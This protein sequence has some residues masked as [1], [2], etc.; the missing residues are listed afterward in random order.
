M[1]TDLATG[2]LGETGCLTPHLSQLAAGDPS[3]N[4]AVS[5]NFLPW[6]LRPSQEVEVEGGVWEVTT[7]H[8]PQWRLSPERGEAAR[9]PGSWFQWRKCLLK[10]LLCTQ[11]PWR[12]KLSRVEETNCF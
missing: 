8:P 1:A 7:A 11:D 3:S 12:D 2:L 5:A 6:E 4:S 9:R 10:T